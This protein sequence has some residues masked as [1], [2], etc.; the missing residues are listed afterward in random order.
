MR[1]GVLA[2]D[3]ERMRQALLHMMVVLV[4]NVHL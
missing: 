1:A 2:F 3:V 4:M